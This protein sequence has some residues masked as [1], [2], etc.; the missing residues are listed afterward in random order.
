M[1]VTSRGGRVILRFASLMCGEAEVGIVPTV[2]FGA[3]SKKLQWDR[4]DIS[5]KRSGRFTQNNTRRHPKSEWQNNLCLRSTTSDDQGWLAHSTQP[6]K[7]DPVCPSVSRC[8]IGFSKSSY[9][10]GHGELM[11]E[12]PFL[13]T[14]ALCPFKSLRNP[15]KKLEPGLFR[16]M[17]DRSLTDPLN[18]NN[19]TQKGDW[20]WYL[21]HPCRLQNSDWFLSTHIDWNLSYVSSRFFELW[22]LFSFTAPAGQK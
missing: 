3:C 15:R 1:S 14:A 9:S 16:S 10:G 20:Q 2:L 8:Q 4:Q 21:S 18:R 19:K 7:L 6:S 12:L 11:S 22:V 13:P 17:I 5:V